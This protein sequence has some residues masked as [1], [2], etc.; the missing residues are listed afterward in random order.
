MFIYYD[1]NIKINDIVLSE[2]EFKILEPNLESLPRGYEYLI[3]NPGKEHE[4][5][6]SGQC[7]I[8]K[9]LQWED[10]D[11]YISRYEEFK[12]LKKTL[13]KDETN[14]IVESEIRKTLPYKEA[15]CLEYP[16]IDDLVIALWEHI[17]ENKSLE[18]SNIN[19]LQKLRENIKSKYPKR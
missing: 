2:E 4:M 19:N 9:S 7:T 1:N 12:Y 15:R 18:D 8:K 16:L 11:R 6:G 14:P 17:V 13:Q 3:Y 10:G 5:S